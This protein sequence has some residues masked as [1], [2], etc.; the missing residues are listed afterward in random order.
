MIEQSTETTIPSA[1]TGQKGDIAQESPINNIGD[2]QVH[3]PSQAKAANFLAQLL[4][5]LPSQLLPALTAFITT[6]ILTRLFLP[7]AY[8][9][10]ALAVSVSTFLVTLAVSGFGSAVVRFYPI[11]KAKSNLNVFFATLLVITGVIVIIVLGLCFLSL[12]LFQRL[13]PVSV[14]QYMPLIVLIFVAQ[15][16]FSVFIAVIR[17]QERSGLYTTYQLLSYYLGLGLGFIL[18]ILYGRGIEGLLWGSFM[19][20]VLTL[21]SL[22]FS[23]VRG[24]SVRLRNFHFKEALQI[25]DYACP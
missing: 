19:A 7:A 24:V 17:A 3:M 13:F 6:P 23:A 4:L 11:Y 12:L 2:S 22:V 21:P 15:S 8:G 14:V 18:V 10:W 1:G 16:V 20:L 25:G 9:N 5:Y